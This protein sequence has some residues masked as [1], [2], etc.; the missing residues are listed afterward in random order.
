MWAALRLRL[1]EARRRGGAWLVGAALLLVF[2]VAL[3]GGETVDG[4]YGL[5][6]DIA[7]TLGY[8]AAIFIGAFPLSIDRER[9]RSYL[10]SASPVS[11]F[12]WALGNALAAAIVAGGVCFSL[13]AAAGIG[14]SARGGIETWTMTSI[15][16][17]GVYWLRP[18]PPQ[19]IQVPAGTRAM[20]LSAR[21]FLTAEDKIGT[22]EGATLGI[23]GKPY[24]IFD[25]RPITVPVQV[26]SRTNSDGEQEHFVLIRNRS[27][28][29][30]VGIDIGSVRALTE[31]RS[32][33]ANSL[34]TG[35]WAALGAGVL[36]SL[37]TAAGAHLGAPI[38]ALA[39]TLLLLLAS[40]KGFVLEI[41][42][43]EGALKRSADTTV[44]HGDHTHGGSGFSDHPM[45]AQ[46]KRV[47]AWTLGLLPNVSEFDRA[48]EAAT[49]R[50][51][52]TRP[53]Y[54]SSFALLVAL[55]IGAAVGGLGVLWRRTP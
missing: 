35:L 34:L 21:S 49:G 24:P 13:Y 41:I 23:S 53:I 28:E 38:A 40:L 1:L 43:H 45:R 25:A 10:P 2:G 4:R 15:G 18:G 14:A 26:G 8:I 7:V 5:A 54:P 36:A 37:G 42:E 27:P 31:S 33:L 44:V 30:A 52:G 6:T 47:F 48:G 17:Q 50:W 29:F 32:F 16:R 19:R 3:F 20:R 22:P 46:V 51:I 9:K 55:L 39:L 11:P 12:G